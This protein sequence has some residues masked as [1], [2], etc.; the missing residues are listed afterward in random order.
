M[1][2]TKTFGQDLIHSL[3]PLTVGSGLVIAVARFKTP[4]GT[5]VGRG[6]ISLDYAV[7]SAETNLVRNTPATD[8][9]YK[10]A[11]RVLLLEISR[12][13]KARD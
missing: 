7:E 9:Q 4:A 3:Q 2:G 12:L 5:D 10:Q 1:V 6:G 8:P 13:Q 11:A